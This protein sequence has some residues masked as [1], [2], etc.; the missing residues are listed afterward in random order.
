[1]K[2]FVTTIVLCLSAHTLIG[3]ESSTGSAPSF[4]P[5]TWERLVNAG[6][7]PHN[8]LMYSGTFSSQRF[9]RLDQINVDNVND[10]ELK[11]AYQIPVIDR[12]ETTPLVV[13]GVMTP[14]MSYQS[15]YREI[16]DEHRQRL[17]QLVQSTIFSEFYSADC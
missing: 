13:D 15:E 14:R 8:W 17:D 12:A 6:D 5:V 2:C 3:Q 10:L 9:S 16:S 11:W 1:M 4:S 7:E